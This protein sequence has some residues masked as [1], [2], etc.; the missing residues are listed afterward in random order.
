MV[1]H[2]YRKTTNAIRNFMLFLDYFIYFLLDP[3]KFNKIN[4]NQIKNILIIDLLKIG[5]LIVTTPT[6]TALKETFP[7]SKIYFLTDHGYKQVLEDNPKIQE[8]LEYKGDFKDTIKEIKKRNIDTALILHPGSLKLSTILLLSKVKYRL[9]CAHPKGLL[10]PKGFF[11]TR[12]VKPTLKVNHAIQDNLEVSRLI[13]ANP[14]KIKL[15]IF[16]DKN[17][18][19]KARQILKDLKIKHKDLKIIIHPGANYKTHEWESQRFYQVS[20]ILTKELKAKVLIT[21]SKDDIALAKEIKKDLRNVFVLAG[22]TT[23][24]ESF[25]LADKVDLII[26]V[27]TAMMHIAAALDKKTIALFGAG[28]T[29]KWYPY[30]KNKIVLFDKSV[31]TSCM[32][33]KCIYKGKRHKECMQAITPQQVISSVKALLKSKS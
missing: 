7:S 9:G 6:L 18:D 26:S 15:E 11:L 32:A 22:K 28:N 31:C 20:K 21:G 5:D 1:E 14:S 30:T 2:I 25:A 29:T 27:D 4:K 23:I 33:A 10:A 16:Y 3:F 19:K 12:K 13:G 24:K 17:S 8:V